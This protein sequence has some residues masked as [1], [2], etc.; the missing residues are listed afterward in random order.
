METTSQGLEVDTYETR[1]TQQEVKNNLSLIGNRWQNLIPKLKCPQCITFQCSQISHLE[2]H[3]ILHCKYR[4][5]LL[6][7]EYISQLRKI[8]MVSC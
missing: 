6:K 8:S 7:N 1:V 2:R 4:P 5:L 3:V